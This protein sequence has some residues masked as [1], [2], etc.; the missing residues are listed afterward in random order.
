MDKTTNSLNWFEIPALDIVR[1][2]KFYETIF[3][4]SMMDMPEMMGMKMAGFPAEMGSGKANGALAQSPMHKPSLEGVIIYL[5]ANPDI[6]AVINRIEAAGGKILMPKM[7]ISKDIGSM[8]FF[9]DTEGNKMGLH[10]GP[11]Q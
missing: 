1:A 8:A 6:D 5:N 2:K 11:V 4:I 7:M 9:A 3:N 10:A